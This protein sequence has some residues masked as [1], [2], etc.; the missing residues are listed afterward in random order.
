[1]NDALFPD[2]PVHIIITILQ[3]GFLINLLLFDTIIF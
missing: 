1:M 3:K 2:F